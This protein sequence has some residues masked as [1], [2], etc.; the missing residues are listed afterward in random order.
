MT[1]SDTTPV[2][3]VGAATPPSSE[4]S[5]VVAV[6]SCSPLGC[7]PA[8]GMW[9]WSPPTLPA[10]TVLKRRVDR[11]LPRSGAPLVMYWA[12]VI[13]LLA[14]AA[15]L[16]LRGALFMDGLAAVVG[17]GWCSLNFWRCRHAHCVATGFG[18]LAFST[19]IF[20]EAA[21]GRTFIDGN[22]QRVLAGLL[23]AGLA[24]EALWCWARGSNAMVSRRTQ[25]WRASPERTPRIS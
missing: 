14:V 4:S 22:E 1:T 3:P 16:P 18:W 21:L 13:G 15:Q 25:A 24:F 2:R 17:G 10:D 8:R 12:V 20:T 23:V 9:G 11:I 6:D 5:V 7:G 19:V